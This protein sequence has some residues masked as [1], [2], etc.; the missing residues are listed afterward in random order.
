[1]T[2]TPKP[3]SIPEVLRDR[4]ALLRSVE[5]ADREFN[6]G[7]IGRVHGDDPEGERVRFRIHGG[8][9]LLVPSR[10]VAPI[11][12]DEHL[13]SAGTLGVLFIA[14]VGSRAHGLEVEGSDID[15]RGFYV[16]A[17]SVHFSLDGA[18]QQLVHDDD[19][20]CVWEI[21]KFIRLALNANPTVLE[22]LYSPA[23]EFVSPHVQTRLETLIRQGAFLSRRAYQTFTG[24]ADSQFEKMQRAR[25]RGMGFKWQ[26]A[27]HLIRLLH[28]GIDLVAT[29]TL[30]VIVPDPQRSV[31][32]AIKAGAVEWDEVVRLRARLA[33][34]FEDA[35][36]ST[37]LP[38]EPDV[39]SAESFLVD[40]RLAVAAEEVR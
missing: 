7:A 23:V 1:L 32:S 5:A 34:E 35:F 8:D 36:A 22:T 6:P 4:A 21:E 29:G 10:D 9:D 2:A 38:D 3:H 27:M 15:R 28:A 33:T 30:D 17:A 37:P 11:R 16:P 12:V 25:D 40:L 14:V 13:P 18:P 26:H 31:L 39:A 24:Y 19:Q 20:L